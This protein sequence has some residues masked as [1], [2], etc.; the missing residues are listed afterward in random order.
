MYCTHDWIEKENKL[1]CS[2]CSKTKLNF[3]ET[4]DENIFT[5][6]REDGRTYT[7][8]RQKNKYLYPEEWNKFISS[9]HEKN[10][11]IFEFLIGTG[12]RIEE[13]LFFKKTD[14][15][16]DKRKVITLIVTKVKAKK[17]EQGMGT[18]RTFAI[19][20]KLYNKL[21]REEYL[22]PFLKLNEKKKYNE[23]KLMTKHKQVGI[24]NLFKRKLKDIGIKDWK[25]YTL[26][27]I[28]KTHGMWLKELKINMTE[29]CNR[30]GHDA[31]TFRKHYGSSGVFERK[32]KLEMIKILGDIY[33]FQ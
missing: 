24:R 15:M 21:Q 1:I 6:I 23:M 17:G 7:L 5:G 27:N 33:G 10:K 4:K 31:E 30:L 28:R 19:S 22:Y 11:L 13:T 8:R 32:D 16:D 14:L 18:P 12:A 9:L 29:I 3:K 2:K 25:L 26:H 20:S